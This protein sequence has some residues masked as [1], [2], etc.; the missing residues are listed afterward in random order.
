MR[1]RDW[2]GFFALAA[3]ITGVVAL[4][5]RAANAG[6]RLDRRAGAAWS[7]LACFRPS[8]AAAAS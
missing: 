8:P 1:R 3:A 2:T 6:F 5:R 4:A 7:Y